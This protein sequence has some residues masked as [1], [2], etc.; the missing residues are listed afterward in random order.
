MRVVAVRERDRGWRAEGARVARLR[1]N[2]RPRLGAA[3]D[4]AVTAAVAATAAAVE[5]DVVRDEAVVR[6]AV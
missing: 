3:V 2:A 5:D 4:A 6:V 1:A